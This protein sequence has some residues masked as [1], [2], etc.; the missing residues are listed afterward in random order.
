MSD[1]QPNGAVSAVVV[2]YRTIPAN[3]CS[4]KGEMGFSSIESVVEYFIQSCPNPGDCASVVIKKGCKPGD[5]EK[6]K[7]ILL[8]NNFDA[9]ISITENGFNMIRK[10]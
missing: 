9:S 6:I 8:A 7:E 5:C 10:T 1:N 3:K 2:N 4:G